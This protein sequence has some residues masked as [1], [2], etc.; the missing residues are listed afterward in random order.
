MKKNRGDEPV[1]VIRRVHGIYLPLP[2][3]SKNVIFFPIFL[4]SST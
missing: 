4:F 1:G 3:T 2:Q